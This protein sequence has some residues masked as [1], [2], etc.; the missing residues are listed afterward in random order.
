MTAL[1][2]LIFLSEQTVPLDQASPDVAALASFFLR[3]SALKSLI[4]TAFISRPDGLG[5]DVK[6]VSKRGDAYNE[7]RALLEKAGE[8]HQPSFEC[9]M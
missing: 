3:I 2:L 1:V 8:R 7:K 5:Q 4:L 9:L 6:H